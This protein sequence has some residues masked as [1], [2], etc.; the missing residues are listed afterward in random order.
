MLAKLSPQQIQS[1]DLAG[2]KIQTI[3]TC[4]PGNGATIGG[5]KV[6]AASGWFAARLRAQK[7]STR[8]MREFSRC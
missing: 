3:L 6:I 2:E 4:A 5:L 8:F 7:T 1:Q